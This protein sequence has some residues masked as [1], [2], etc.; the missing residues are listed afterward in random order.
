MGPYRKRT[1]RNW[2]F[3]TTGQEEEQSATPTETVAGRDVGVKFLSER[4]RTM[5]ENHEAPEE[6][7]AD[8]DA[9]EEVREDVEDRFMSDF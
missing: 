2:F 7:D 6:E 5:P 4:P 9:E 3:L 1:P 8:A